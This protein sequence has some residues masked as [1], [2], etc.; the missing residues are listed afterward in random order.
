MSFMPDLSKMGETKSVVACIAIITSSMAAVLLAMIVKKETF[1]ELTFLTIF[2]AVL[3]FVLYAS[4][5]VLTY[6]IV[7]RRE[8]SV[9][10]FQKHT[11]EIIK[12]SN[13]LA[14]LTLSQQTELTKTLQQIVE[15]EK[16]ILNK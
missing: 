9:N 10:K 6:G 13:R 16:D 4:I 15:T 5:T 3:F 11:L 7:R 14:E 2:F 8:G 1:N 12:E